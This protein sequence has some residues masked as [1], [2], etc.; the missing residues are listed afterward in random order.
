MASRKPSARAKRVAAFRSELTGVGDVFER[1]SQRERELDATRER[2]RY[3][4]ACSSKKRYPTRADAL[5]AAVAC[6][7][8][9]RAGLSV[10]KCSYCN[11]WHLTSHPWKQER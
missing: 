4:K 5:E 1:E 3:E 10:Y 8:H 7:D 9:G 2:A 11:G 6:A